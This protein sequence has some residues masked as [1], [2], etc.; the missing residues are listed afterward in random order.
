MFEFLT[1]MY[2]GRK[3]IIQSTMARGLEQIDK[4]SINLLAG[5]T[6]DWI[7]GNIPRALIGGGF[8]SRVIWVYEDTMRARK[9]F[10]NKEMVSKALKLEEPLLADLIHF[11]QLH[12][13]F[14]IDEEAQTFLED[15][16]Q[17]L[18]KRYKGFKYPGYVNRKHVM[19][20][21][22]CQILHIAYSDELI[23]RKVDAENAI[24][25]LESVEQKLD[26]V[27]AGVGRNTYALDMRGIVDYVK[28]K[29]QVSDPELRN[30]FESVAEPA[31]LNE[32][33]QGVLITGKIKMVTIEGVTTYQ[34]GE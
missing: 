21:K 10:H 8:A 28:E 20:L 32:L 34:L 15:W 31:K 7:A 2:D 23:I 9:L 22:L 13:E 19:C 5:T 30:H 24:I 11:S 26:R 1:S 12:G 18:E 3:G 33:I 25:L 4:P 17:G 14:T 27:F 29:G 6:P 16:Y